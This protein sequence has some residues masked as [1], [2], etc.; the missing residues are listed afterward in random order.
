MKHKLIHAGAQR[1]YVLI[2]DTDDEAI[3]GLKRFA[4][5][6][7]LAASHFTAIGAFRRAVLGYFEWERKDYKRIPVD[8]QVEVVSL[9]GDVATKDGKPAVHA[10]VVLG[11]SEGNARGGH[12]LEGHVRPTLE[13]VLTESPA[14]LVREIDAETGL[15]LIH[16]SPS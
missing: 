11:D 5:S 15:P 10:H 8:A 12:L 13:V 6:E 4:E 9:I 3:D 1:T 7:K 16:L 14:Y 2:F